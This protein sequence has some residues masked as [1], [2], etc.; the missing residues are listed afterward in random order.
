M[1]MAKRIMIVSLTVIMIFQAFAPSTE[2][3]AEEVNAIWSGSVAAAHGMDSVMSG[4]RNAIS[5]FS[6]D[7]ETDET[8]VDGT[9]SSIDAGDTSAPAG[10]NQQGSESEGDEVE[11]PVQDEEFANQDAD[12]AADD[13]NAAETNEAEDAAT[14]EAGD[15]A[16][17]A[18]ADPYYSATAKELSEKLDEMNAGSATYESDTDVAAKAITYKNPTGLALISHAAPEVYQNVDIQKDGSTGGEWELSDTS[19]T[20]GVTFEGLGSDSV[21]F[22]G[23]IALGSENNKITLKISRAFFNNVEFSM[24]EFSINIKWVGDDS[25]QSILANKCSGGGKA[26]NANI[27]IGT[28]LEGSTDELKLSSPLFGEIDGDLAVNASYSN[29]GKKI[30]VDISKNGNAGLLVNTV[31]S[32][33]LIVQDFVGLETSALSSESKNTI[34]SNDANAGGLIG[35]TCDQVTVKI[36]NPIDLSSLCIF[37][38]KDSGGFIGRATNLTLSVPDEISDDNTLVKPALTVGDFTEKNKTITAI[39]N[40]AGGA[41]GEVSFAGITEIKNGTFSFDGEVALTSAS[42]GADQ[43]YAGGLFGKLDV[44]NGDVTIA[45][46]DYKSNLAKAVDDQNHRG[47][48]GGIA[49]I[50]WD[51]SAANEPETLNRLVVSDDAKC[52]IKRSDNGN[53][54]YVGGVVGNIGTS[55]K[56]YVEVELDNV[57]VLCKGL[58]YAYTSWGK[59]GGAVGVIAAGSVLDAKDLTVAT[60]QGTT[61]GGRDGGAAGLVGSAWRATVRLGGKT[62]LSNA[63]FASDGNLTAQLVYENWCS[64]IFADGSGSDG[65]W[66]FERPKGAP[67]ADDIYTYGEVIRLGKGLDRDLVSLDENTHKPKFSRQLVADGGIYELN[68]VNDF[69]L[70]AIAWQTSGQ[71]ASVAGVSYRNLNGIPSSTISVK[72]TIDL[73]GTGLTGLTK[74]RVPSSQDR[75]D[76]STHMFSGTLNGGGE[77]K[78]AVGE[79]YG[80]SSKSDGDGRIYRH[81]RLGLF[82]GVN[83]A[84]VENIKI[85]GSMRFDNKAAVDAGG[86]AAVKSGGETKLSNAAFC[87]SAVCDN[88]NNNAATH[89][90]SVFGSLLGGQSGS[91]FECGSLKFGSKTEVEADV[92]TPSGA[93]NNTSVGGVIGYIQG[94]NK[95]EID[96]EGLAVTSKKDAGINAGGALAGGFIGLISQE[97]WSSTGGKQQRELDAVKTILIRSLKMDGL[98]VKG[99]RSDSGGLLGYSWGNAIVTF[100]DESNSGSDYALTAAGSKI[101]S[102]NATAFGGL[103][104]AASGEWIINDKAINLDEASFVADKANSFGL[105][106]CCGGSGKVGVESNFRGLY[107]ED[108]ADWKSAYKNENCAISTKAGCFDEWVADTR[109]V[110]SNKGTVSKIDD[111]GVNG[112]I[113]LHTTDELLHMGEDQ[114]DNSYQNRTTYGK[115]RPVNSNARY[116]YNVDRARNQTV[117]LRGNNWFTT[118]QQLLLWNARRYAATEIRDYIANSTDYTSSAMK[119]GTVRIGFS[120][121]YRPIDLSGYSY[122]PVDVSGA[123]IHI[124]HCE[125]KFYYKEIDNIERDNKRNSKTSQHMNMHLG[126]LR[127]YS[128]LSFSSTTLYVSNVKLSGNTGV[129]ARDNTVSGALICGSAKGLYNSARQVA[130]KTEVNI[131]GLFLDGLTIEG[132]DGTESD[133]APLLINS[134][135]TYAGLTVKNLSLDKDKYKNKDGAIASSLFGDLGGEDADMVTA[136]FEKIAVPSAKSDG[137]FSRAS[138]LES[139]GYKQNNS[140]SAVYNFTTD[141]DAAKNVTYGAEID[142]KGEYAGLQLGY[143]NENEQGTY[144][145]VTDAKIAGEVKAITANADDPQFAARYLPYVAVGEKGNVYHEIKVNQHMPDLTLGCGTYGDPYAIKDEDELYAVSEY[146]ANGAA[147]DGWQITLAMKQDAICTRRSDGKSDNEATYEYSGGKWTIKQQ[148]TG[149]AQ[150]L[151]KDVVQSYLQSAYFSI[152]PK[153]SDATLTVD[154]SRF[155]GMG[156]KTRPFRG[157]IV[158]NLLQNGQ[159][160][161]I[162][163]ENAGN[164]FKGL[165]PYS[166][167]S[168]VK[169][170]DVEYDSSNISIAYGSREEAAPT[171]FFGGV[172]GCVLGGD[173]I[174]ESVSVSG[175]DTNVSGD[176]NNRGHL[177][178]IGGYVGVIVGGGVIF[179]GDIKS[180]SWRKEKENSSALYDNPFVGRVIDG[181]AFS[182]F[183]G[184]RTLNNGESDYKVNNL[185]VDEGASI[186][187]GAL[188]PRDGNNSGR[189]VSVSVDSAQGL[190]VL[191][192]II[193]SGAAAGTTQSTGNPW[194]GYSNGTNAYKGSVYKADGCPYAFGNGSY[195]KVRNATYEN[196]GKPATEVDDFAISVNDDT[197]TPGVQRDCP[198]NNVTSDDTFNLPYLVAKYANPLT[199][200]V[201]APNIAGLKIEFK[202]TDYDMR[203]YSTGFVGL[204]G[205]YYANAC[206]GGDVSTERDRIVPSIVCIDGNDADILLSKNIKQYK[207]DDYARVSVGGLFDFVMFTDANTVSELTLNGGA[208]VRNLNF[209]KLGDDSKS[210]VTLECI[211]GGSDKEYSGMLKDQESNISVGM[212]AGSTANWESLTKGGFYQNV[213]IRN[214]EILSPKMAGG[215]LGNSGWAA[216]RNIN[217]S[218][219]IRYMINYASESTK[220]SPVSLLDC[221][222]E[223]LT[224]TAGLRVGGYV[225]AVGGAEFGTN[226]YSTVNVWTSEVADNNKR[227]TEIGADSEIVASGENC[228]MGGVVGLSW[229]KVNVNVPDAVRGSDFNTAV[230]DNVAIKCEQKVTDPNGEDIRGSGGLAGNAVIGFDIR[231]LE[232]KGKSANNRTMFGKSTFSSAQQGN[233][234]MRIGGVIGQIGALNKDCECSLTDVKVSNIEFAVTDSAGGLIGYMLNRRSV[235]C[236]GITIDNVQFD[237]TYCGGLIGALNNN[238]VA[239]SAKNITVKNSYFARK[240]SGAISGDGKGTIAVSNALASNNVYANSDQG[241]L[242]GEVWEKNSLKNFFAAGI[243]VIPAK[244]GETDTDAVL[245]SLVNV[246]TKSDVTKVNKKTYIAFADYTKSSTRTGAGVSLSSLFDD[247]SSADYPLVSADPYVAVNPVSQVFVCNNTDGSKK[248]LFGD[249]INVN[250][251]KTI[252]AD[253]EQGARSE[254]GYI[255]SN[256]GGQV[257]GKY[258][259]ENAYEAGKSAS[260]FNENNVSKESV[261]TEND[262]PVLLI[263]GNDTETVKNYLNIITNGGFSDAVSLNADSITSADSQKH[264]TATVKSFELRDVVEDGK[265]SKAFVETDSPSLNVVGNGT[266]SMSFRASSDWDNEKHRFSLLT[267]SFN[268]AGQSYK[269]QVPIIVKRMLEINFAATYTYGTAFDSSKYGDE[270]H[271][272][273]DKEYAGYKDHVL[274]SSGDT[275][276]GYLTW[277]YNKANADATEYG[278]NTHLASGGSMGPLNKTIDFSGTGEKGS[279]PE[280]TQLT[281]VDIANNSREYTCVVGE[282]GVNGDSVKLTSFKDSDGKVYKEKWLSETMGVKVSSDGDWVELTSEEVKQHA[283]DIE[284]YAGAKVDGKYYRYAP[285]A[286]GVKYQLS[287]E[288]E[289]PESENFYLIVRTPVGSKAVNGFTSTTVSSNVNTHVN[290]VLR[291]K[292]NP[293][294]VTVNTPSTYS[295]NSSYYQTLSDNIAAGTKEMAVNEG[296]NDAIDISVTDD[297]SFDP[298]QEYNADDSLYYQLNSSLVN[299]LDSQIDSAT[300]YPAGSSGEVS[301]FVTIAGEYYYW[302]GS[303][304]VKSESGKVPAVKP[305]VWAADNRGGDMALRLENDG[306]PVDLKHIREL[307]KTAGLGDDGHA[308]FAITTETRLTMTYA[309]CQAGIAAS[310][311]AGDNAYT[312]TSFR[313]HLSTNVGSLETSSMADDNPGNMKY[314][315][316]RND[317]V[318]TISLEANLTSQLGINVDDLKSSDHSIWL[319]GKYD[320]KEARNGSSNLTAADTV[321][322][323]LTLQQRQENG[324]YSAVNGKIGDYISI[325]RVEQGLI[326]EIRDSS[327]IFTDVKSSAGKFAT[328]D[329]SSPTLVLGFWVKVNTNVESA[330][331]FYSNYRLVLTANLSG[332]GVSDKET[333]PN[334]AQGLY[335]YEHSDYVT[336]TLTRVNTDG[337]SHEN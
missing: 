50:V 37:G 215:L 102:G 307:A 290:Q 206:I 182:E 294:D 136:S 205:R 56:Y 236:N 121:G 222:Y 39:T 282:N 230:L 177:V 68:D 252:E 313:S 226:N 133:R 187:T 165:V 250:M 18:A 150:T 70:L 180:E 22:S 77:I 40:I 274:L 125:I 253:T 49:G 44:A 333:R 312:R 199:E 99:T 89:I 175:S 30:K 172:V 336:Y 87:T 57:D 170:L 148:K 166:Y 127:N 19:K 114:E 137:Y 245:P 186:E 72:A 47:G 63:G 141:D 7:S 188:L 275:M 151:S 84:T 169:N 104:Y 75:I 217:D 100:G 244:V 189:A 208:L 220:A 58:G 285:D 240:A 135:P 109:K 212:L 9:G 3:F 163:I 16:G 27:A 97:Y 164:T 11:D 107:I 267:V 31:K 36:D 119:D 272:I 263:P 52:S 76:E 10:E 242:L 281:L 103:L 149:A 65:A 276:T 271:A 110:D 330:K 160:A 332:S 153:S 108:R 139:F 315:R 261:T 284:S 232:I 257:D 239:I 223:Q 60:E 308:R 209:G 190:L 283:D 269:V 62:D 328:R 48:Y 231:N 295:I 80:N 106:V 51:S 61:L 197:R 306:A 88:S 320:F 268:E 156:S 335:G 143:Y 159:T 241:V 25:D 251:A 131:S 202:N 71:F 55:D 329:G 262:F 43:G 101:Q 66:T 92:K 289:E 176:S 1:R 210:A 181:Y 198:S 221:S 5:Q 213:N 191:S 264:V 138:L 26:V 184:G 23:N 78:L 310:S 122:Y 86:L 120:N 193:S 301:F 174:I 277:T 311:D 8:I 35:E 41:F 204:S 162:K 259:I 46:G 85:G 69:A 303:D 54:A 155:T 42:A 12:V 288:K 327:I 326:P 178:P 224:V 246:H 292:G 134:L 145:A 323:T 98:T 24:K 233:R 243:L 297:I 305:S 4:V 158:G 203:Q 248:K 53:L 317:T 45:G 93:G 322:Y 293:V 299:Y 219:D 319:T 279:M 238:G 146:I 142:S 15:E 194:Y 237:G 154:G 196:V 179:R 95:V 201:C 296:S 287:V 225:G 200:F 21:P 130:C 273:S 318:P 260:T 254:G 183:S 112:V 91:L 316:T 105:L 255:Y 17:R 32:G 247:Q 234:V 280:G 291:S 38:V 207:D 129:D 81:G 265:T 249:G 278:W 118:P 34:Q 64:L 14:E 113:S 314:Y 144:D 302:N 90:G 116:Y 140:G 266:K 74:D 124:Q 123:D 192:A 325:S 298:N 126:L 185:N 300:G 258:T 115:S 235:V 324:S 128:P 152:E 147:A 79:S 161:K 28:T 337:I 94:N 214:A 227:E 59:Y 334:N 331:Q 173:N 211:N 216:R 13:V 6:T 309:A 157:V 218:N 195:G 29:G 321:T 286:S 304:W 82:M 167:G 111:T 2:I 229:S 171:S 67:K 256:I 96:V 33:V 20:G 132:I 117:D 168:V 270:N 73:A 228:V 83:G